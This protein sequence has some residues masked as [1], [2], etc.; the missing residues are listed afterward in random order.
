MP[1][2]AMAQV[3]IEAREAGVRVLFFQR[4]YD[5]RQAQSM[6]QMLG[7]RIVTINPLDYDWEGQLSAV[8]E[9]LCR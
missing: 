8:V 9:A 4:E 2:T 1:P 5:S 3:A 7:A 6:N